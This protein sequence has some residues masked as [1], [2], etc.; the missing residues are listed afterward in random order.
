[1]QIENLDKFIRHGWEISTVKDALA[2]PNQGIDLSIKKYFLT[3]PS[4]EFD[5]PCCNTYRVI[6]KE[7]VKLGSL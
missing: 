6:W 7:K 2:Y 4:L 5:H 1:M 3:S